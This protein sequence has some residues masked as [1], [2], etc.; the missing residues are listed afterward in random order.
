MKLFKNEYSKNNQASKVDIQ[1]TY[2]LVIG[3]LNTL[4]KTVET[5]GH[6]QPTLTKLNQI[7][8]DV[9]LRQTN[10]L[11]AA[12]STNLFKDKVNKFKIS[13]E[14]VTDQ[15]QQSPSQQYR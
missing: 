12:V 7:L 10:P 6:A 1:A 15:E 13:P 4:I 5:M 3:Q 9:G 8:V 11:V 2:D 14:N